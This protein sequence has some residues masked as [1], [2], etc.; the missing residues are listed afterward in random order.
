MGSESLGES[1]EK[2]WLARWTGE[3]HDSHDVFIGDRELQLAGVAR[4]GRLRNGDRW[5]STSNT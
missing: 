4:I 1:L 2:A 5:R 3:T